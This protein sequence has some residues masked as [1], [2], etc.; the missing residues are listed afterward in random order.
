MAKF[1]SQT[2]IDLFKECF[3]FI[4]KRGYTQDEHQMGQIMRSLSYSPTEEEIKKYFQKYVK[5]D[6]IDFASFLEVMHEHN[7][8]EKAV[9]EIILAFK[10]HDTEGRGYVQTNEVKNIL[11]NLGEQLTKREVD[12][13]FRDGGVNG[14]QLRYQDFINNI[15]QPVPDY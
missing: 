6:R 10:A 13:L 3:F 5:D 8:K 12:A 9:K 11:A 14:S 15:S 4:A 2:D 1:F 7:M